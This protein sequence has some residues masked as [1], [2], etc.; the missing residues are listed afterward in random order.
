MQLKIFGESV[1]ELE[2]RCYIVVDEDSKKCLVIDPGADYPRIKEIIDGEKATPV[3][4]LLTHGHFD[5]VGGVNEFLKAGVK[6]YIYDGE[7]EILADPKKNLSAF[8]DDAPIPNPDEI[9]SLQEKTYYFEPFEVK[10]ILTPG[11]TKGSVCFLIDDNLF[12]GDTLFSHGYGRYD[13]PS[14]NKD[15]LFSS[16]KSLKTL[17][18]LTAY[19]G[20]GPITSIRDEKENGILKDIK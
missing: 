4:V 20:H 5:H 6:A 17:P 13:L 1:G 12:C 14:G 18:D 9:E 8:F 15:E 16:L 7:K 19:P 3:A 11:H 10:V 2:E